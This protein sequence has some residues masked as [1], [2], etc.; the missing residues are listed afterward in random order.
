MPFS[1]P[2]EETWTHSLLLL[3]FSLLAGGVIHTIVFAVLRRRMEQPPLSDS[4][5]ALDTVRWPS[6]FLSM[7]IVLL[8]LHPAVPFPGIFEKIL[9][10]IMVLLTILT[11]AWTMITLTHFL[12]KQLLSRHPSGSQDDLERRKVRT[13][14]LLI[15][16]LLTVL[17][18]LISTSA[19]LMTIPRI[20]AV[21]ES[22]LA[23]A[24]LAGIVI[25]LAARPLLT[26]VIAGIQIALTQP[27]RIDDVVIVDN[28]WGWIEEIGIAYVVVRIWDL[29]RLILPLSYF[30]E[31]PFENWTY[32]SSQL[33][34]YV[35]IYADYAV[36]VLDLREHLKALLESTPLWDRQTWNLQVTSLDEKA[37]QMRALFSARDSGSRWDLSVYVR[38]GMLAYLRNQKVSGFPR[39]RVEI[40]PQTP[41]SG[42]PPRED[43]HLSPGEAPEGQT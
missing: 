35:H 38:E 17:I 1:P 8:I 31:Q 40:A 9:S 16:R 37:V 43:G 15:E 28:E 12:G 10:R 27:I 22:L 11:V 3:L 30:I 32:K 20:R 19:A 24:G 5:P 18:I 14:V 13:R 2:P 33:L 41:R 42:S 39:V 34:G 29:R 6:F 4:P 25:G 36:N 26:N 23:S 7:E 21:G